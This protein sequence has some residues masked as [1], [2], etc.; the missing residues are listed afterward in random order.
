MKE[1]IG[2]HGTTKEN[3][4]NILATKE[5][6]V[7]GTTKDWLGKGVYF[8]EGDRHQAYMFIKFKNGHSCILTHGKICVLEARIS[9]D[10]RR[11]FDLTIYDDQKFLSDYRKSIEKKIKEEQ[12]KTG[13]WKHIEGFV[14]EN[15]C[16]DFAA[17]IDLV[18]AIYRTPKKFE[19]FEDFGFL[20]AQI[21]LCVKNVE[22]V[23]EASIK[24]VD[25]SDYR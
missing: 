24:E 17:D 14:I 4:E 19:N 1:Y 20:N 9:V 15:L 21:Q 2:Y 22:C 3:G 5:F 23:S 25:C 13:R 8:F 16:K 10:D 7:S 18:R 11:V 6:K 12:E